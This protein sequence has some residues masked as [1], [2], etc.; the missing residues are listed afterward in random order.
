MTFLI[1]LDSPREW[2][3]EQ[4]ASTIYAKCFWARWK[5]EEN[6]EKDFPFAIRNFCESFLGFNFSYIFL[7]S[8]FCFSLIYV[9]AETFAASARVYLMPN[10]FLANSS[11][12]SE[13]KVFRSTLSFLECVFAIQILHQTEVQMKIFEKRHCQTLR[14]GYNVISFSPRR[15]LSHHLPSF[16]CLFIMIL[17]LYLNNIIDFPTFSIQLIQF[18]FI[19]FLFPVVCM[20]SQFIFS[21]S[22][23]CVGWEMVRKMEEKGK[24]SAFSLSSQK[25][26]YKN[27]GYLHSINITLV[28][29]GC[30][31]IWRAKTKRR[32]K[33]KTESEPQ[34]W[35]LLYHCSQ[36]TLSLTYLRRCDAFFLFLLI[37]VYYVYFSHFFSLVPISLGSLK[38]SSL[39]KV[40]SH[41]F[42]L[43]FL[44]I[45]QDTRSSWRRIPALWRRD[46]SKFAEQW[47]LER[48]SENVS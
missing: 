2:G 31:V 36:L 28:V 20:P 13:W 4:E 47:Y 23:L 11:T 35:H 42:F 5:A 44:T 7:S 19:F 37:M 16:F 27:Y 14:D 29:V 26:L 17:Q 10:A 39:P 48:G 32:K 30:L 45:E 3:K 41:F 9:F 24:F 12:R 21:S 33:G 15:P 8:V 1:T 43:F 6:E 18:F 34:G 25:F 40:S 38:A 46:E 22:F